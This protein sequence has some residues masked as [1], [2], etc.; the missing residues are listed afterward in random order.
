M[1]ERSIW[2]V[3]CRS[4]DANSVRP[5]NVPDEID[6]MAL[7]CINLVCVFVGWASRYWD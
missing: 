2:Q 3:L 6:V 1:D 4:R 5:E 7:V